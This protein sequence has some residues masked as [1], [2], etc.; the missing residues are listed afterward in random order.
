MEFCDDDMKRIAI[1]RVFVWVE[2]DQISHE[3]QLRKNTLSISVLSSPSE[4]ENCWL[5]AD[6]SLMNCIYNPQMICSFISSHLCFTQVW[7]F[8]KIHL[9]KYIN[10]S[11]IG[12]VCLSVT[13]SDSDVYSHIFNKSATRH[14]VHYSNF[15]MVR[16]WVFRWTQ[17][18]GSS[19]NDYSGTQ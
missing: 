13:I 3:S 15:Q 8:F 11:I 14:H 16:N 18:A 19:E 2:M 17:I 5:Y 7:T 4:R 12:F 10:E 1:G 6:W 9:K